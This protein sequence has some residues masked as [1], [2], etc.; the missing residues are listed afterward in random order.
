[1]RQKTIYEK[2]KIDSSEPDGGLNF[3]DA[4]ANA[5]PVEVEGFT[6]EEL[7]KFF[8]A[9]RAEKIKKARHIDEIDEI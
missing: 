7:I 2:W 8:G 1:M 6:D 4:P 9:D 5:K 3:H